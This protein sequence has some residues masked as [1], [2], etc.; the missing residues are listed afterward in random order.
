M[1]PVA[2]A[3]IVFVCV[4]AG[5]VTGMI[6]RTRVPDH[7]LNG[8]SKDVVK[9][10]M[11][12]IGTMSALVLGLLIGFSKG[13][14]DT[15]RGY[16]ERLSADIIEVDRVL[17]YYG[18][19]TNETRALLRQFVTEGID[20]VWPKDNAETANL[21]PAAAKGATEAFYNGV[22]NLSPQTDAQRFA[23][24]QAEQIIADATRTRLLMYAQLGGSI[25]LSLL[26]VLVSW[27]LLLFVGFGLLTKVNG[28]IIAVFLVGALSVAGA[29]FLVLDLNLPYGGLMAISSAPLQNA[30]AYISQ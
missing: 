23:K 20:Q 26:I 17:L 5:A 1:N 16:V 25:P 2:T 24:D 9:L 27:L 3:L 6:V 30:L 8:D 7:H 15:Q 22:L 18:P 28:T 11:G 4:F 19:G 14:Y 29:I 10:V 13:T 12:L 21:K